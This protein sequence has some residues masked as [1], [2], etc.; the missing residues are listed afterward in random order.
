MHNSTT[1][2]Q[3]LQL[4]VKASTSEND[5]MGDAAGSHRIER[6]SQHCEHMVPPGY[7]RDFR[8]VLG[9][10]V[11]AVLQGKPLGCRDVCFAVLEHGG[12]LYHI[13]VR[14]QKVNCTL[15]RIC[16]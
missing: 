7:V 5:N 4:L 12:I 1:I 10:G 6:T 3:Q 2:Q 16:F 9:T 13:D 15:Q 14:I 8:V 11:V